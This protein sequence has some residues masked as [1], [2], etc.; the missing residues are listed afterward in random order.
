[1]IN[2]ELNKKIDRAIRL[3]RSVK[4]DE[5]E[6]SYSGGKDSDVILELAKMADIPYRAI[7]KAT[8]IDPPGTV[9]HCK[10]NGAQILRPEFNFFELIRQHGFPTRRARFCCNKLKEY[11]VLDNAIQGIRSCESVKRKA[12]YKEPIIC[13]IYGRKENHVN[14]VLPILDWTDKDVADFI[15]M[16][17]IQCH[18]LYYDENGRFDVARRLGCVACPL[19]GDNGLADFKANPALVRAW[20]KAG[21]VWWNKPREKE[22]KSKAKFGDI[23]GLFVHNVFFDTYE[24]FRL[25]TS[26]M[27]GQIDCKQFLEQYFNIEL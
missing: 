21:L 19:Q 5:I 13:R 1:M 17:G 12:R 6:L 7:Y 14:V 24:D 20:I 16:R 3:L 26:G 2:A 8:T 25:A 23:Y 10:N 18:S 22:M 27:F 4:V 9:A 15:A 11:K